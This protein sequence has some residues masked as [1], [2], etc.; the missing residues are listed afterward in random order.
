MR[1]CVHGNIKDFHQHGRQK[2]ILQAIK[3]ELP[4]TFILPE[5]ILGVNFDLYSMPTNNSFIIARF[6]LTILS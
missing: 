5:I 6:F 4:I 1:I 3:M 2:S